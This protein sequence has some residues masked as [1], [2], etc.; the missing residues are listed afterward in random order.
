METAGRAVVGSMYSA[1]ADTAGADMAQVGAVVDC[2]ADSDNSAPDTVEA[3]AAE[4]THMVAADVLEADTAGM[5]YTVDL[6][7]L[8]PVFPLQHQEP[9]KSRQNPVSKLSIPSHYFPASCRNYFA[10][11]YRSLSLSSL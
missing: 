8:D 9:A 10:H 7:C 3:D 11:L 2:K 4:L 1:G 6:N 5:D